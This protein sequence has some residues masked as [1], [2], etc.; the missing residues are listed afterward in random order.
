MLTA[1]ICVCLSFL[2]LGALLIRFS[3]LYAPL[4]V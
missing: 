4:D 2:N 1:R 3:T